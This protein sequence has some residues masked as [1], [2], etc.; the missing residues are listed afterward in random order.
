MRRH[1]LFG[2]ILVG[3]SLQACTQTAAVVESTPSAVATVTST[4]T[5]SI[6]TAT[7]SDSTVCYFVWAT[8]DLPD[9]SEK[10]S[11]ELQSLDPAA[12]ASAYSYG[13]DCVYADGTRTF[14][15]M[16][17]DFQ[18]Q[19]PVADLTDKESLGN[20]IPK[21]MSIILALPA[22]ELQG[23]NHGMAEFE[24]QT[25]NSDIRRLNVAINQYETLAQGLT[26]ARLFDALAA[27]P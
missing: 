19:V 1:I 9:L 2:L 4:A 5:P 18:I 11:K 25:S 16:E 26:G 23:P 12:S 14:T 20:W 17:T 21:V 22:A 8:R 3:L 7:A 13:E 6:P 27:T 15:A 24:F 10:L